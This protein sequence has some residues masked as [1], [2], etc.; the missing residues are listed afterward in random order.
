MVEVAEEKKLVSVFMGHPGHY[1]GR[2]DFFYYLYR[3]PCITRIH[4]QDKIR[5]HVFLHSKFIEAVSIMQKFPWVDHVDVNGS[6]PIDRKQDPFQNYVPI[7]FSEKHPRP[8]RPQVNKNYKPVGQAYW[9]C[10]L[11]SQ[12]PSNNLFFQTELFQRKFL[13]IIRTIDLPI[14][15]VGGLRADAFSIAINSTITD[16]IINLTG[17]TS[18]LETYA[19][20]QESQGFIGSAS[21]VFLVSM[22]E[23]KPVKMLTHHPGYYRNMERWLYPQMVDYPKEEIAL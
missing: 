15:L 12:D 13:E 19:L 1:H 14:V 10:H 18:M 4:Q 22:L 20:I 6:W 5:A 2:G 23:R 16:K 3:D 11:E 17:R 8:C 21:W 9:I 7:E